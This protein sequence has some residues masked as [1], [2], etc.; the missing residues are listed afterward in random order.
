M[1]PTSELFSGSNQDSQEFLL[2]FKK[3]AIIKKLSDE[4]KM[5]VFSSYLTGSA[6]AYYRIIETTVT[7]YQ[8]LEQKIKDEFPPINNYDQQ[9]YTTRQGQDEDIMDY[10]YRL[11]ELF[12]KARMTDEKN[13]ISQFLNTISGF[14]KHKLATTIYEDKTSLKKLIIQLK[15]VYGQKEGPVLKHTQLPMSMDGFVK[16]LETIQVPGPQ[17]GPSGNMFPHGPPG[18]FAESSQHTSPPEYAYRTP[19][20]PGRIGVRP[21]GTPEVFY[22]DPWSAEQRYQGQ[23][24][25]HHPPPMWS[26]E[27][28]HTYGYDSPVGRQGQVLP[29]RHGY[30]L[31]SRV[32]PD[33]S[34][35][36]RRQLYP[37]NFR[38][39][40]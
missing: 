19:A 33:Q 3:M 4:E 38:R 13:F 11:L 28:R 31:R 1:E 39:P 27:P 40:R 5:A 36:V 12:T 7:T 17:A 23:H 25:Y 8:E 14:Y 37:G 2:R 10:Y 34:Q 26:G 18:T 35:D 16:P 21:A 32:R 29:P 30:N 20:G 22:R 15:S 24:F 9:F 6:L